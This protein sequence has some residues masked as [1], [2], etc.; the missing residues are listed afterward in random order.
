M[1][2]LITGARGTVGRALEAHLVAAGGSAVR[3]DRGAVAIDDYAAMEA[4]VKGSGAEVLF[5]LAIA[6]QPTGRA[7]EGWAVN[8]QW[9]SELAWICRV[10]GIRFVFTSTA[11]VFSDAAKG[12]FTLDSAPDASEGYGHQKLRAEERVRYQNPQATIARLGWQLGP[13]GARE[14]GGDN[15]MQ[16]FFERNIAEHGEIRASTRWFPAC[17][18]V[19]DTAAALARLAAEPPGLYMLDSNRRWTFF[20]IAGAV[21]A[22]EHRAWKIVATEDFVYDQ[23]LLDPRVELPPLSARLPTLR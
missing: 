4:F 21:A 23:R 6:S 19:D 14:A 20:E 5:H 10:L 2:A 13:L 3:W 1:R 15:T 7:D 17:S 8:Y 18:F 22:A 9:T 12:P 16:R 11:M